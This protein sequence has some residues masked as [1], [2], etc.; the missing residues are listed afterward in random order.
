MKNQIKNFYMSNFTFKGKEKLSKLT[1]L[2]IIFLDIFVLSTLYQGINFQTRVINNP[3]TK[4]PYEC[5]DILSSSQSLENFNSYLYNS[6]NYT[7]NYQNIKDLEVDERCNLIF[8]KVA[9]I[10]KEINIEN[11]KKQNDEIY[12]KEYAITDQISY[13]KQ[14]YDTILFEKMSE[15]KSD[16]SIIK[17]NLSTENIKDKYDLLNIELENLAKEKEKLN[18]EFKENILIK[19]FISYLDLNKNQILDDI[20]KSEKYYYV[21]QELVTLIFLIP[22]ILLFFYLMKKYL[23]K[24][25]YI[26]YIIFKNILLITSIPTI[27]SILSLINI[28][29]PKIFIEKLLMLF[30]SLEIPFVVYYLAIGLFILVFIFIIIKLQKRFKDENE[31]LKNNQITKIESFN[32]NLCNKCSNRVDYTIMNYCPC[33]QNKLKIECNSCN[34]ATIKG[35]DFCITCG[36]HIKE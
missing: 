10:K 6:Y 3:I 14:N 2:A 18:L 12:K 28:F 20:N 22:L 7:S 32:K 4:Y 5:R 33:C 24:E 29:I 9:L 16:K 36:T 17:G 25:K 26:L 1:I 21:K 23:I 15:Q 13:L 11:F 31:R 19:D 27:I 8:E 34:N 35:L 30:Y